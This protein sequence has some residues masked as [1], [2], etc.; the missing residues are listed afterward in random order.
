MDF[1][2]AYTAS[3]VTG[4]Y[5]LSPNAGLK[6]VVIVCP[7]T[8]DNSDTVAIKLSDY[9][10]TNLLGVRGWYHSTA[11]SVI[12]RDV[13]TTAVSSGTLTITTVSGSTDQIRVYE[14][15]GQL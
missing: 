5:E 8:M 12:V 13:C 14:V 4:I 7:A 10:M 2:T 3:T 15:L 11:N 1:M 9:G 6:K